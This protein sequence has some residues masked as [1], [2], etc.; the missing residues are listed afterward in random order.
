MIGMETENKNNGI[1]KVRLFGRF[2]VSGQNRT[3]D[4]E[5]IRSEMV[6]KLLSYVFCHRKRN[7]TIQELGDALWHD[8]GSDNPA[9]ALKNLMYRLRNIMKKEW[10]RSDFIVTGRGTYAWNPEIP[11]EIDAEEFEKLCKNAH[12]NEEAEEEIAELE[13]AV[14]LYRG[15]FLPK[16]TGEYWVASLAT[17]YHSMYLTAVK[18]LAALLEEHS[19]YD[20]MAQICSRAIDLDA[21]DEELHCW[22]IKAL[23]GQ[24]KQNLAIEH[25]QKTVDLLYDNL[26]VRP[27][28]ELRG[29]YEEL[30][31]QK[32]EQELDLSKIQKELKADDNGKGAFLCEYG[33]FKKSYHLEIRRA[34]RLGMSIYLSLITLY[35]SINVKKDSGAYTN[36]INKGMD[37]M[38]QILLTSLRTGDV[39][40]RYSSTQFIIMLPTCQ[41]ETAMMVMDRIQNRFYSSEE[42]TKIKIQYSVD[43]IDLSKV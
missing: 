20:E 17:Y 16:L 3:L 40:S 26:G 37:M 7:V 10:E 28:Q 30:L 1:W 15:T 18:Q 11:L 25:Y 33:V 35:P 13:E 34:G 29:V 38:Q 43:E 42:K 6:T 32:H 5:K 39:I 23:I 2:E 41:Y 21:L 19:R 22:F 9:G 31:K 27:S 36:I 24:N 14:E 8:D 12:R 4:E